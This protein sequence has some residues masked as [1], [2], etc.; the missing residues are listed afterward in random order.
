MADFFFYWSEAGSDG[1]MRFQKERYWNIET[2]LKRWVKN[3]YSVA[4]ATSALRLKR[5]KK[6][7]PELT[8]KRDDN[9]ARL[10]QEIAERKA[11][12]V[13]YEEWLKMKK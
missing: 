8:A 5:L 6:K 2:R 9:N 13:S 7:E 11:S 1:R 3:Q 10:E 12:A 4:D